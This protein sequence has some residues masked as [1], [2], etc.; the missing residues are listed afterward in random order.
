MNTSLILR[1]SLAFAFLYPPIAALFDPYSWIGYFPDFTRGIL[2]DLVLLHLFGAVE[3]AIGIWLLWGKHLFYPSLAAT[4]L[5]AA[6]VLFN[7]G[8][9]DVIFRDLSILGIALAL[10]LESFRERN[11]V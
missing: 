4:V 5:L 6:I 10:A 2:P 11:R 7:I 9:M 1:L 3:V 8:Q